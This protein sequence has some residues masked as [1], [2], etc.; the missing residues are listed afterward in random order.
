MRIQPDSDYDDQEDFEPIDTD[1]MPL[2]F[3]DMKLRLDYTNLPALAYVPQIF[4]YLF[5]CLKPTIAML[6]C[7]L[8]IKLVTTTSLSYTP[9]YGLLCKQRAILCATGKRRLCFLLLK[10]L[11]VLQDASEMWCALHPHCRTS[12]QRGHL[13]NLQ[14]G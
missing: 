6:K 8:L 12:T 7:I 2:A 5:V 13:L 3:Q 14:R 11:T 1:L 4:H 10:R 9:L